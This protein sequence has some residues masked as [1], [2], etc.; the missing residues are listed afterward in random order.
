MCQMSVVMNE[1]G[2]EKTVM[3]NVAHLETTDEGI[4]LRTLF[5]ESA[6][7]K[8]AFVRKIDF[9]G[10]RVYLASREASP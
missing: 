1:N 3:E 4:S 7:I 10:G 2:E 8:N 5:E 9:T 6:L